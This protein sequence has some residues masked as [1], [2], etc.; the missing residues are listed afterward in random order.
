[1]PDTVAE[2][3]AIFGWSGFVTGACALLLTLVIVWAGPFAPQRDAGVILGELAAGIAQSATR[4]VAG[5]PQPEPVAVARD[6]DDYLNI[7]VAVL[8][9]LALVLGI[10][11]LIRHEHRQAA[12]SGIV[13]GGLA[14]GVQL[15]AFAVMIIAGAVVIAGLL[16]SMRDVLG[17]ILGN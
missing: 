14:I 16:Y 1:M 6:I 15:F 5:Q 12:V 9:G 7:A 13:L 11:A 10:A 17:G 4:A 2:P 3:R 8:A